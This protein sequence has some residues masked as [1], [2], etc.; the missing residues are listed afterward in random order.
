M[1][2]QAAGSTAN[3]RSQFWE[4]IWLEDG[5][6]NVGQKWDRGVSSPALIDLLRKQAEGHSEDGVRPLP[7]GRVLVPGC[8]RGY[9]LVEFARY[10]IASSEAIGA[11][12][13][14]MGVKAAQEFISG[15]TDITDEQKGKIRIAH[16]DFFTA[17]PEDEAV[18]GK[19]DVAYDYTFFCAIDP[20][21]R[22]AWALKYGELIATGGE[23]ITMM[24][25]IIIK[26]GGPP[27]AVH[28]DD[29]A[30]VLTAAGFELVHSAPVPD[31]LSHDGRQGKEVLGRWRRT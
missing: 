14:P 26:E 25:P 20:S 27:F 13:A 5:G 21:Q 29:Y 10:G 9:D 6:T 23:L 1:A 18:G 11:D 12:I 7:R 15:L 16:V 8:G 3:D 24:Y 4:N 30:K 31:A 17:K 28:P 19:F 2:T 22:G